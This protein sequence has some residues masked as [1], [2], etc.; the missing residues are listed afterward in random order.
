MGLLAF[1]TLT[2]FSQTKEY[3]G[4]W[5]KINTTYEFDFDLILKVKNSNQVE[6]YFIWKVVHYNENNIL[7]KNYYENKIG[8]TAKEYVRGTFNPA[9]NEYVLN[10]FKKVPQSRGVT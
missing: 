3:N 6:G 9:K 5:T 7:S 4:T 8:M 10:G 1:C 2:S